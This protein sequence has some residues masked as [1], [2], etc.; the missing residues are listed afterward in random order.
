MILVRD[1][2]GGL[3]VT[4]TFQIVIILPDLPNSI[5]S[6]PFWKRGPPFKRGLSSPTTDPPPVLSTR[7]T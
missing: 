5:A 2:I 4:K 7:F 1:A 6:S 3:Y